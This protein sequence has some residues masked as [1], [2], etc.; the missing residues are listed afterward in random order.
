MSNVGPFR[1]VN[2]NRATKQFYLALTLKGIGPRHTRSAPIYGSGSS[3]ESTTTISSG[4]K[5]RLGWITRWRIRAASLALAQLENVKA[6][7]ERLY[8][9]RKTYFVRTE[10]DVEKEPTSDEDRK[11]ASES[12]EAAT[13]DDNKKEKEAWDRTFTTDALSDLEKTDDEKLY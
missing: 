2:P 12:S 7:E 8:G 3:R 1:D 10:R 13:T 6:L 4:S 5:G 11:T 9:E